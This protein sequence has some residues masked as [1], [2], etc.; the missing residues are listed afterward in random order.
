MARAR[1]I[2]TR[3]EKLVPALDEYY[4]SG[5]LTREE[6]LEVSRQRTH[7]EYR[8]VA[9]PLL[10][11]DVRGAITYELVLEKRL[12]D[13][14]H[15]TKLSLQHRWD[16]VERIEGI[17]KIGLKHLKNKKEHESLR[18]E[19][20]LFLKQFQ[21][22]GSLSNLY[23]ELMV[24][25]PRRSDIW[26]EAAEWQCTLQ[27][28]TD[29][30]RAILQQALLTMSSE[31][32]VWACALRVELQFAQR[33][34][35]GLLAEH[36]E[37][38]RKAR[39][40][41]AHQAAEEDGDQVTQTVDAADDG[42][43]GAAEQPTSVIAPKLRAENAS[44]GQVLLDLALAKT[45]VE[46]S[47]ESPASGALL[48]DQLL[49]AAGA[50]SFS[51]EV[52]E[53]IVSTA[54]RKMLEACLAADAPGGR[55]TTSSVTTLS[56][57]SQ[58]Q[59]LRVRVQWRH[60]QSIDAVFAAYLS[61]ED[62]LVNR[63][64]TAIVD[65]T[66]Y[67]SEGGG[68][69]IAD[70]HRRQQFSQQ[71]QQHSSNAA[72]A[73]F[74]FANPSVEDRRR[75]AV[76]TLVSIIT[77]ASLPSST[78]AALPA[79]T[80]SDAADSTLRFAAVRQTLIDVLRRLAGTPAAAA[81]VSKVC[82]AL[83]QGSFSL[84]SRS[85]GDGGAAATKF[86]AARKND[87]KKKVPAET[88]LDVAEVACWILQ[89]RKLDQ[90]TQ[91]TCVETP[92]QR[93]H[94]LEEEMTSVASTAA[95]PRSR[96]RIEPSSFSATVEA[97]P[98][99]SASPLLTW[100]VVQ[101]ERFLHAED[102]D[103]LRSTGAQLTSP[104]SASALVGNAATKP[105]QLTTEE[106][107]RF[108]AWWKEEG[109][110]LQGGPIV[111]AGEVAASHARRRMAVVDLLQQHGLLPATM[112]S[113]VSNS[114]GSGS[115]KK[116]PA[117]RSRL[118]DTDAWAVAEAFLLNRTTALQFCPP[119]AVSD[120]RATLLPLSM[121]RV[122]S[123]LESMVG[124]LNANAP[125]LANDSGASKKFAV[126][127]SSSNDSDS[128]DDASYNLDSRTAARPGTSPSSSS[129]TQSTT[130]FTSFAAAGLHF[131]SGVS[132]SV[133]DRTQ[134]WVRLE[135]VTSLLRCR[136][137]SWL[138]R[139]VC[140]RDVVV[141]ALRG[142]STE[143]AEGWMADLQGL[144]VVAQRCQPLP[145]YA[146]THCILPFLEGVA[147]YRTLSASASPATVRGAVQAAREAHEALLKLYGVSKQPE[148]FLPLVYDGT[149]AKKL[150]AGEAPSATT[151][152]ASTTAVQQANTEDWVAYVVFE[153][154]VSKDLLK[155]KTVVEQGRRSAL[156]PQQLMVKL[157]AL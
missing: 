145:R 61:M 135:G 123:A 143:A 23:G 132:S 75:A 68:G 85:N 3:L 31:P 36:R 89:Q 79:V 110:Q 56:I 50:F 67:L 76:K 120:D 64:A 7:W 112:N 32:T 29:N 11:L 12:R 106:V 115:S 86:G 14:C 133:L 78:I 48:M 108:I 30:A 134:E 116:T 46:E 138:G 6:T 71:P 33:L 16:I 122:F 125:Y 65:T 69:A 45:V 152:K 105:L 37:E 17:Y 21:R 147:V 124:P 128:D 25:Y 84:S 103:V 80:A 60:R 118:T 81:G 5:F 131:L 27:H 107:D 10:L 97:S 150:S 24:A 62:A 70:A 140:T 117:E 102:R 63:Y 51:K 130:R 40:K 137:A 98:A 41:A 13:Y 139:R 153:R 90:A 93:V 47:F 54:T 91:Q 111:S 77:F 72:F 155:A 59:Q 114:R 87:K 154:T 34:L 4:S 20:V 144:L 109:A 8:L 126:R 39:R 88:P 74:S 38:A 149:P 141:E 100:S 66:T 148:S 96:A 42:G 73:E 49:S 44:M 157:N 9:K 146:H 28:N 2:E 52:M 58:Q 82:A 101:L 55:D 156:S 35:D 119:A 83:L 99:T 127:S 18:Q 19:Y 104:A 113:L 1:A 136:L 22:N 57:V 26:V 92:Q 15:H 142:A 53:F 121:W 43:A 95:P 94:K 129:V 151:G